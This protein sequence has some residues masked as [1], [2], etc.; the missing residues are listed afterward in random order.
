MRA[1]ADSNPTANATAK[2]IPILLILFINVDAG[3]MPLLDNGHHAFA[4]RNLM[5]LRVAGP[6]VAA[7]ADNLNVVAGKSYCRG[8]LRR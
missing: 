1:P 2:A 7:G 4:Q 5:T 6:F 8:E 3:A